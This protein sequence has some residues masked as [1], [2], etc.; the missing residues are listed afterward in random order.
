MRPIRIGPDSI[1]LRYE[2]N[3]KKNTIHSEEIKVYCC[4]YCG[5]VGRN[6]GGTARHEWFC[7]KS[8]KNKA[9]CYSC[10]H[11]EAHLDTV[12]IMEMEFDGGYTRPEKRKFNISCDSTGF[13]SSLVG[14][15]VSDNIGTYI[16]SGAC[17]ITVRPQSTFLPIC[18]SKHVRICQPHIPCTLL[19]QP[20]YNRGDTQCRRVLYEKMYVVF[21]GFHH[22]DSEVAFVC[23]V[24][25]GLFDGFLQCSAQYPSEIF[26]DKYQMAFQA[27][28]MPVFRKVI[29]HNKKKFDFY[30]SNL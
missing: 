29:A 26:A 5:Y 17:K 30:L 18:F 21:V 4:D 9:M 25:H 23:D 14:N 7:K 12:E 10:K 24:R 28:L 15:I 2:D 6:P 13:A 22:F 3:S 20:P 11:Y 27:S 8:P 19:L 16:T 1:S